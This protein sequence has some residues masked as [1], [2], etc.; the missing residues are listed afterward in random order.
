[1]KPWNLMI[2]SHCAI[3]SKVCP[4]KNKGT[5]A[6]SGCFLH[7][8]LILNFKSI[9]NSENVKNILRTPWGSNWWKV[10]NVEP[11]PLLRCSYKKNSVC[12]LWII[13]HSCC[14]FKIDT[15]SCISLISILWVIL[16]SWFLFTINRW[17]C[18]FPID[19]DMYISNIHFV[20][21]FAFLFL[22]Y[23]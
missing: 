14:L 19:T 18:I 16:Y 15:W 23:N 10:K 13:L 11:Q 3:F 5:P 17:T 2:C 7:L 22:V 12:I 4:P 20:S 1:M 9:Q 6:P 21:N 8:P